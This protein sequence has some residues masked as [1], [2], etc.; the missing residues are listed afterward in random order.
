V[1]I[2]IG[3]GFNSGYLYWDRAISREHLND[4]IGAIRDFDTA[5]ALA[6]AQQNFIY[7]MKMPHDDCPMTAKL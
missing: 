7:V 4:T 5:I 6:P 1:A 2:K 3:S